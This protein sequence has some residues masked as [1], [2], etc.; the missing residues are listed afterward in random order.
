MKRRERE[1]RDISFISPCRIP[2]LETQ[3]KRK[4]LTS[5]YQTTIRLLSH[6]NPWSVSVGCEPT[7]E[8]S[9]NR[10]WRPKARSR[11]RFSLIVVGVVCFVLALSRRS[12]FFSLTGV[13]YA[14]SKRPVRKGDDHSVVM[15][16]SIAYESSGSKRSLPAAWCGTVP[17]I[18][19]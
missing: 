7:G 15:P 5:G 19:L 11:A 8:C 2:P 13:R 9:D 14:V 10:D 18:S 4:L 3:R 17:G 12:T 16:A 6:V 1:Q